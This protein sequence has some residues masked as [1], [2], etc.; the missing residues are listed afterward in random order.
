[1]V[2]LQAGPQPGK[3]NEWLDG[4]YLKQTGKNIG[5]KRDRGGEGRKLAAKNATDKTPSKRGKDGGRWE[6]G[7]R[8]GGGNW[9][10]GKTVNLRGPTGGSGGY[11]TINHSGIDSGNMMGKHASEK[12]KWGV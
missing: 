11:N 2:H 1:M 12:R 3:T 7:Q 10:G 4:G 6:K 8:E 9:W 5:K